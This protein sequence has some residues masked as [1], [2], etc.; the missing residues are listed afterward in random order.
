LKLTAGRSVSNNR[1]NHRVIKGLMGFLR[2]PENLLVGGFGG[3]ILIGAAILTLPL[4]GQVGFVDALFT[5]TS[6]VCVTGLAVVDTEYAFT[7]FG[8]TVILLLIQGGGLGIMTFAA[9][10]FQLLGRRLSLRSRTVLESSFFQQDIGIE[11]GR[12]FRQ[13]LWITAITE[14]G[15][16]I[17]ISAALLVHSTTPLEAMYAALF[18]SVSAFCNA[19]FSTYSNNL[20][21]VRSNHVFLGTIMALIVIGG[22]GHVVVRELWDRAKSRVLPQAKRSTPHFFSL[23]TRV[24]LLV[25]AILIA[26]GTIGLLLFGLTAD[27]VSPVEQLSG[28]LFQSIT[29]RTAGFNSVDIDRLPLASLLLIILL[30][31]VGGSPASCAGGIKTTA[32]A[33]FLADLRAKL[34]GDIEV[35]LFNRSIPEDTVKKVIL[36]FS[37]SF[38]WNLAG[39]FLLLVFESGK[40]MGLHDLL[41]E[42]ASAFATVGLST[43]VTGK[44]SAPGKLWIIATMFVGRLGPLTLAVW[45]LPKKALRI[46]HPEGRIL[47]G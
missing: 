37:V 7:L 8:K 1:S 13:I 27:E 31:F 24:V 26:S 35:R 15:G 47:I 34:R 21:D 41:F 32:L 45:A 20:V 9:L 5:S 23:H 11:F 4:S 22:L 42:Q 10:F 16:M 17:L 6:A 28:A 43:G 30:M 36:L 19:G 3:V 18:H 12:M 33:V 38:L 39:V 2:I 14:L 40:G 44:L 46:L 25:T 29:A